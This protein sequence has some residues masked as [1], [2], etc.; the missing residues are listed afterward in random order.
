MAIEV[1]YQGQLGNQ[2]FQYCIGKILADK[3]GQQYMPRNWLNKARQP[4]RWNMS[5]YVIPLPT[6]GEKNGAG[7]IQIN[8]MHYF[9]MSRITR[10]AAVNARGYFQ[11]YELLRDYKDKIRGQWLKLR[12]PLPATDPEAV[13][14]HVR[15]TDYVGEHLNPDKQCQATTLEEYAACLKKFPDAKRM[16]IVSDNYEDDMLAKVAGLGLPTTYARG[17][18]DKDFLTLAAARW[19]II[20]Q[21][22]YSWWAAFL[23]KA[24]KVVC[25]VFPQTYWG[26]GV[27]LHGHAAGN[28]HPNLFVDDEPGKWEWV[29]GA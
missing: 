18:W 19:V 8:C 6:T 20:S 7:P 22:T 12:A 5:Q 16:V 29:T 3:T 23:G 14:V 4:L 10:G 24:E 25:P 28:D 1:R 9:D 11:R 17:T 21:S 26:R 2:F 13:Y 15:R 27:G